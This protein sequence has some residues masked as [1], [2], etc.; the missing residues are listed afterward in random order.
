[1]DEIIIYKENK[2]C[3]KVGTKPLRERLECML[4]RPDHEVLMMP[5]AELKSMIL[6]GIELFGDQEHF[7]SGRKAQLMWVFTRERSSNKTFRIL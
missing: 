2:N 4:A 1:M 5:I 6:N 7:L 3:I